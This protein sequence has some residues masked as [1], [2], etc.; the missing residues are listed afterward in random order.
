MDDLKIVISRYQKTDK[1]LWDKYVL[2][3][4]N[5]VSY[6]LS[7]WKESIEKSYGF[8]SHYLLAKIK[9]KNQKDTVKGIFPLFHHR[10]PF[11]KGNLI[12]LPFCDCAGLL[13]DSEHVEAKLLKEAFHIANQKGIK[14]ISIRSSH[15]STQ[16]DED[17]TI[18]KN[19]VRM[20]LTLAGKSDSLMKSFKSKLRSQVKKSFRDGLLAKVGGHELLDSFYPLF[21]ENMRDLGSPVHSRRLFEAVLES[22]GKRSRLVV[23]S[24]RD[25]TPAAGGIILCHP[26]QISVPWASSLRRFNRLNPNMLLYWTFLEF[27]S[28]NGFPI[29][30]FG[31]STPGEGTYRFKRQ[32]GATPS[33]LHWYRF[34]HDKYSDT[35][36][37]R[38][39]REQIG[40]SK[41]RM[42]TESVI[43]KLPVS[44]ATM[45]GHFFR[46]YIPL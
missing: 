10:L 30:D 16:I 20:L 37:F 23:V 31:R 11:S 44:M 40:N 22:F 17:E 4:P 3:H 9:K 27:A 6:H 46:K 24:L 1:I 42:I 38:P 26:N 8:K 15:P 32:W 25:K 21:A 36:T 41:S 2:N 13:S 5:A 45:S 28:D 35:F 34:K 43:Q 18:N 39:S 7:A 33:P 12:S 14:I 19:K 29:F